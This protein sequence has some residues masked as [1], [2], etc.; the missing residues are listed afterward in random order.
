MRYTGSGALPL[1]IALPDFTDVVPYLDHPLALVGY[2]IFLLFALLSAVIKIAGK[3][4][5]SPTR[6]FLFHI[7]LIASV[8]VLIVVVGSFTVLAMELLQERDETATKF[9]SNAKLDYKKIRAAVPLGDT[10][11][12]ATQIDRSIAV[13]QRWRA[14]EKA[15]L[16]HE[17]NRA[18][19]ELQNGNADLATQLLLNRLQMLRAHRNANQIPPAEMKELVATAQAIGGL[20]FLTNTKAAIGAYRLLI[21]LTPEDWL[22]WYQLSILEL[23][24]GNYNKAVTAAQKVRDI[25]QENKEE[26]VVARSQG[27]MS[28]IARQRSELREAETLGKK[29]VNSLRGTNDRK[30]LAVELGNLGIV[31]RLLGKY[32]ESEKLHKEALQIE[33][34]LDSYLGRAREYGNLGALL[35]VRGSNFQEQAVA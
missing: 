5:D 33:E 31:K 35:R 10:K 4:K 32:G 14:Q 25:G 13:L 30:A 6:L 16:T 2:A 34:S 3:T 19:Q 22:S 11:I 29:A 1:D 24:V 8:V 17:I 9:A 23:R 27:L 7:S 26:A 21:K 12:A 20:A 15:P 18:I 28:V